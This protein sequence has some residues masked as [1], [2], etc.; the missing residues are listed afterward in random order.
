[1]IKR[2]KISFSGGETSA[3]MLIWAKYNLFHKYDE[4]V[5][6]F[7]NTSQENEQ[8]LEF[9]DRVSKHW[10]IPVVWLE[11]V[12]HHNER[13]GSTHKIVTFETASRDGQIFEEVIKKYGIPNPDFQPCNRELKVNPMHSYCRSIGWQK[14]TYHT[15]IG[16][17][18]DEIDRINPN[19]R[20]NHLIYPLA[21]DHPISKPLINEF[22]QKQAFRLQLKGYEGN[23]KWC[24]KKS[25]R[26][27]L[28]LITE[29][30]EWYDFPERME[31]QYGYSGARH[32]GD[33]KPRVFFRQYQSVKDLRELSKKGGFT[34]S[35]DDSVVYP[36][37]DLFG[38]DLDSTF[39]CSESCEINE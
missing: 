39:G 19:Y 8:T 10:E 11:A 38:F 28:T 14:G 25:L 36:E 26:K 33:T 29:H 1:M 27:H 9:V 24:W 12:V 6:T 18:A 16:I 32:E 21:F 23:C 5:V 4:V 7:A 35:D 37:P 30:P 3:Y 22:W 34:P 17:R 31:E 20:D 15:A 2:L 13:K